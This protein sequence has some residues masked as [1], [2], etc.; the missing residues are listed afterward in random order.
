M[1]A[2]VTP[3]Q[4]Q[5]DARYFLEALQTLDV[6]VIE[7]KIH[8]IQQNE[9][10]LFHPSSPP[11]DVPRVLE[12]FHCINPNKLFQVF[13]DN[14][15]RTFFSH[16]ITPL[17]TFVGELKSLYFDKY[18][19]FSYLIS[20]IQQTIFTYIINKDFQEVQNVFAFDETQFID[21]I[22]KRPINSK[23]LPT[24]AVIK[25]R[26]PVMDL[27][28]NLLQ[29]F[30]FEHYLFTDVDSIDDFWTS[31]KY[32]NLLER[33]KSA[34]ENE[35]N[36][37][38]ITKSGPLS[39]IFQNLSNEKP[40]SSSKPNPSRSR[41]GR[42]LALMNKVEKKQPLIDAFETIISKVFRAPSKSN[43]I[44]VLHICEGASFDP[45]GTLNEM[46]LDEDSESDT[47]IAYQLLLEQDKVVSIANWMKAF[48]AR[49]GIKDKA[50]L[51]SRFQVAV[52]DLEYL[53][54]ID[55]KTR[56]PG[57]FRRILRV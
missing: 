50:I 20:L 7:K 21:Q 46:L 53:G 3:P 14:V 30:G 47:A 48:S 10:I 27:T 36:E 45:R 33:M 19:S 57:T 1:I 41:K 49:V 18:R 26:V 42:Q 54:L 28:E 38:L 8:H 16:G 22:L 34:D 32:K 2:H 40:K 25:L 13:I 35:M 37:F 24:T 43:T 17:P 51:L 6:P 56:K 11:S 15:L 55:K 44:N 12:F 39:I 9:L 52:S 4:D 23:Y 5:A 31:S 29:H